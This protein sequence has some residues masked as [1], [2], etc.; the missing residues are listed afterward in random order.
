MTMSDKEIKAIL[1]T[2]HIPQARSNASYMIVEQASKAP[3]KQ[4]EWLRLLRLWR[5]WLYVPTMRY[6]VMASAVAIVIMIGLLG[7]LHTTTPELADD[8]HYMV[9]GIHILDDIDFG[10]SQILDDFD[11]DNS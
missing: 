9:D 8:H 3:R 6:F 2:Q 10:E 1:A 4:W 7:R 5:A 11:F